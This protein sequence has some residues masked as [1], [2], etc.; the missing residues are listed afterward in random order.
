MTMHDMVRRAKSDWLWIKHVAELVS[1]LPSKDFLGEAKTIFNNFHDLVWKAHYIRYLKDPHQVELVSSVWQIYSRRAADCDEMSL[2]Y[3]AATGA[4]GFPY[5]FV[6]IASDLSR[7]K[8]PSHVY[9]Q[10]WLAQTKENPGK[11]IGADLTVK[12]STF[13][14]QPPAKYPRTFWPELKY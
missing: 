14:W 3:A 13:G 11:W 10:I 2:W 9:T 1:D 5:R 6:T 12:E 8:D 4:V 7:P